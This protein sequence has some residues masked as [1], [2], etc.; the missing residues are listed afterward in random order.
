[1]TTRIKAALVVACG[2]VLTALLLLRTPPGL[3]GPPFYPWAWRRLAAWPLFP[4]M[5]L[6]A[7]P[8]IVAQVISWKRS[9]VGIVLSLVML[10]CFAMKIAS[11]AFRE[12]PPSLDIVSSIVENESA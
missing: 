1:M 11:G 8:L 12:W 7:L 3:N 4:A 6:V 5:L 2:A 9:R 10:S